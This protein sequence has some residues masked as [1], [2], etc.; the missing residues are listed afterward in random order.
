MTATGSVQTALLYHFCRLR[1]PAVTLPLAVF[2]HH[3]RRAFDL[4]QAK[5]A[6]SAPP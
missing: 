2:E 4:F 6:R 5:R 3:L 1:L